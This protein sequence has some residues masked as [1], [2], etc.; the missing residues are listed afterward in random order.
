[1]PYW[2]NY[3]TNL[4]YVGYNQAAVGILTP[5][6][7]CEGHNQGWNVNRTGFGSYN[8]NGTYFYATVIAHNAPLP[9]DDIRLA[10]A[11]AGS[12]IALTWEVTPEREHVLGYELYRS[13]DGVNFSR[14]AQVDKQGRTVYHHRDAYVQPLTRYFYRVDQ[15]DIFGNVRHSNIA[16]AILPGVGESFS[17]QIYPQPAVSEATLQ[18]SVPSEGVLDFQVYDA[19]GKLVVKSEYSLTAGSH[20]IDLTPVVSRLAIG[21]YNAILTFGGETRTVRLVKAEHIR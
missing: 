2:T 9:S 10:A 13:L 15:H 17:A 5:P 7:N 14:I 4:C 19:A 20:R 8:L 16:E 18:V 12:A 6:N 1:D 21:N 3:P 11:P